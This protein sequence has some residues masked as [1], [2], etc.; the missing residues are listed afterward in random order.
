MKC[1]APHV[2]RGDAIGVIGGGV[3]DREEDAVAEVLDERARAFDLRRHRHHPPQVRPLGQQ[4]RELV[5]VRGTDRRDVLRTGAR[6]A[7]VRPLEMDAADLRAVVWLAMRAR[8]PSRP[9]ADPARD[10]E[11]VVAAIAVVPSLA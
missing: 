11:S 4:R 1:D 10:A 6:D 2:Q 8:S 9:R 3:A 5:N 7:D